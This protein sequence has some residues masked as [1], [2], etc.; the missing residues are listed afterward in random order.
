MTA[1]PWILAESTWK[2]VAV[3]DYE[4]AVLP[5]GAT[6][7]HNYH[8]PY[9]TD[10]I[11]CDALAAESARI[12]WDR[13]AKVIVLPAVPFGVNT[14]QLDIK[15]CL[16]MNPSTQAA[17]LAD[18][19]HSLEAQGIRKLVIFNGHGGNDFRQMI[20][21]LQPRTKVFLS[22]LNW[23]KVGHPER[24]FTDLGDH[25]GE[26]ETSVMQ[27]VAP[28]MVRSLDEAGDGHEK[29]W[30]IEGLRQGWA[31]AP[32]Q[33]T[34]VSADTGVG[35]PAFATAH[36]GEQYANEVAA[37]VADFFVELAAADPNDL[38]TDPSS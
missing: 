32:R 10:T 11:Q 9:G 36:K 18:I 26:L 16:N 25:A 6:E 17:V 22:T 23:Y 7:A 31:W 13:G 5:W 4:V 28:R 34:K 30:R 12:A 33:W 24:V 35:N 15:L 37:C 20:R 38:Y 27:H 8:L 2:T 3:T 21:E 29:R 1:R 19:A 14:G